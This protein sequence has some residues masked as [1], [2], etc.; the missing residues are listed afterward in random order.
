MSEPL[1]CIGSCNR[2]WRRAQVEYEEAK[3]AYP[4]H[5]AEIADS[6]ASGEIT[7][8]EAAKI[9][10]EPPKQPTITPYLGEPFWCS[11]CMARIGAALTDLDELAG[12]WQAMADGHRGQ[13]DK[14]RVSGTSEGGSP[15][16]ITDAL[17]E[18]YGDLRDIEDNYREWHPELGSSP[19]R[20]ARGAFARTLVASWLA[21]HFDG[22]ITEKG[23]SDAGETILRWH[24]R[25]QAAAKAKP[26]SVRKPVP[27]PRCRQRSLV[28]E[29][30]RDLVRCSNEDCNR[31]MS[32]EDYDDL[33][34]VAAGAAGLAS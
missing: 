1:V 10:P 16:P 2:A 14:D 32:R 11:R 18:L 33:A 22:I 20:G 8:E 4:R 12:V 15:S 23:A 21:A 17:D 7:P 26:E 19:Y 28:L 13:P 27:C 25:I 3:R 34:D 9:R 5:L 6:V 24:R 29:T 30:D 31:V